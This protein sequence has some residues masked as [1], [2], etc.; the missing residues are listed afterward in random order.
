MSFFEELR[1]RYVVKVA[2]AYAI[3]GWLLIA[4]TRFGRHAFLGA[5][6]GGC[7][8]LSARFAGAQEAPPVLTGMW[9]TTVTAVEHPDWTIEDLFACNCTPETYEYLHELLLPENDQLSAEEIQQALRAHNQAAI[10][11]LFTEAAREYVSVYDLSDD[12][13]I[14]CEYFGVFRTVLHSDPVLIEQNEERI[15][16][17]TEDMA[18][19]RIIYMDGRGHPED[20][21]LSPLGHSIGWYEGSTLVVDTVNVAAN[22]AEDG[23]NIHNV[24]HA[25]SIERYTLSEDGRRLHM[26]F[27]LTDPAMFRE[28][29]VLERTRL[30]TPD[31]DLLDASCESISGQF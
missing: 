28:P 19:D 21:P 11:D 5:A 17:R 1:R 3:V 26:Q 23:L 27:T 24:D 10:Q 8:V 13:S 25:S 2:V 4:V 30:F 16:I 29:L 15:V 12:T 6:I 20:G 14:Q 7:L 9:S 18:S 22:V 31:V